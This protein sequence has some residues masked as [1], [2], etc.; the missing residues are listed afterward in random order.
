VSFRVLYVLKQNAL[1]SK[2]RYLALEVLNDDYRHLEK[3]DMFALGA[4]LFELWT[5]T[6]LPSG[7]DAFPGLQHSGALICQRAIAA[8]CRQSL[9]ACA[10]LRRVFRGAGTAVMGLR[11]KYQSMSCSIF[12]SFH[13]VLQL[14]ALKRR[15]GAVPGPAARQDWHAAGAQR[16]PAQHDRAAH[17]PGR[18]AAPLARKG[19]GC[20][21]F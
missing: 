14:N 5:A 12:H 10:V 11:L 7:A 17:A 1:L 9:C 4:T 2:R 8:G 20:S 18:G 19:D 13:L 16:A 21:G 6:D 15:G 3:A